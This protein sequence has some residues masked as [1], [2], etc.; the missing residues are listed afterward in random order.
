MRCSKLSENRKK[1]MLTDTLA[2]LLSNSIS[3]LK[4][5]HTSPSKALLA[6]SAEVYPEDPSLDS[7]KKLDEKYEKE[8]NG[9]EVQIFDKL[10]IRHWDTWMGKK[11]KLVF[12]LELEKK[13]DSNSPLT[14]NELDELDIRSIDSSDDEDRDQQDARLSRSRSAHW[15]VS[16]TPVTPMAGLE[17]IECPVGPFGDASDF[18]ISPSH[19]AFVSKDPHLPEAWHTRMHCYLV[20]L[21]PRNEE[22]KKPKCLS[23]QGGARSSPV[24]STSA[25]IGSGKGKLA[26]LEM[27]VDKYES[28]RNRVIVYDL[29]RDI[30]YGLTEDWELSPSSLVWGEDEKILYAT[31]EVSLPCFCDYLKTRFSDLYS[32]TGGGPQE[33]FRT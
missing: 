33:A 3:D 28:D 24:F 6:F 18:D 14:S 19:L 10:F 21:Q 32:I 17:N 23:S 15:S 11:K 20:P 2:C 26:W 8:L 7:V 16:S 1:S 31:V 27:R 29:E 25:K 13:T 22:E 9:A 5:T 12:Y 30:K 4:V